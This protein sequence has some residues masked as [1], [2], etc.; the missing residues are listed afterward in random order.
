MK[1]YAQ[2]GF[3]NGQKTIDGLCQGYIDGVILSPKDTGF[4]KLSETIADIQNKAAS[5]DILFDPQV[6]ACFAAIDP[7]S[8]VGKLED[9]Y[10]VS[11]GRY[12]APRRRSQ[13]QSEQQVMADLRSALLFQEGI[14][15][16]SVIAPNILIP[17]SFD[18]NEASIAMDFIR[19]SRRCYTEVGGTKPLYATLAIGRDAL[20]D[21]EELMRF[22]NEI[23]L[24]EE[25]P[26]GYYVLIGVNNSEA[27][28]D[29]YNADVIAAWML[30]NYALSSNR[31]KIINGY[32]D[33]LTPFLGACG[34]NAGAT[35][36]WA[37]LR[38]FSLDRFAPPRGG[39]SL[40]IERYLSCILLNRVTYY[41]LEQWHRMMPN[42][43]NNLP[44]DAL[45][46]QSKGCQP[47]R[48]QEVLQS[49]NAIKALNSRL[50]T[51]GTVNSLANCKRAVAQAKAAYDTIGAYG[52]PVDPKS[53]RMHLDGDGRGGGL[54]D[55]L[56]LFERF[57]EL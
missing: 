5:S 48:N 2:C 11:E 45:Y 15:V 50:V 9:D 35:G 17:R 41:E 37:N 32:S 28:T 13:L 55:G 38:N 36:W 40:P 18:S 30:V 16:T 31:L 7:L 19:N 8:R 10:G 29:I 4:N 54:E 56:N 20:L 1:L 39:G 26:D 23:T 34:A 57:A 24:L 47:Q 42:L 43:W 12:F 52:L 53:N 22:L 6:Y 25:S 51:G 14:G 33:I 46:P 44:S 27:R 3:G 49:W 21:R